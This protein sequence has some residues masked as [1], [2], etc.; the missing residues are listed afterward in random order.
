M[1]EKRKIYEG[2]SFSAGD[3]L[4]YFLSALAIVGGVL[5]CIYH[6]SCQMT[7]RGISILDEEEPPEIRGVEVTSDTSIRLE[8][9]KAVTVESASVSSLEDGSEASLEAAANNPVPAYADITDGGNTVIFRFRQ[10]TKTGGR[11]Q[12][13]SEI[14]DARGDTLT[15]ALPFY[16][17][18]GSIPACAITEVQPKKAG[19][20]KSR[21]L[22]PESPYIVLKTLEDGNLSGL[23]LY[24][25]QN[26]RHYALPAVD[27]KGGETLVLHLDHTENEEDCVSETGSDLGLA[28]TGRS[29][30]VTRDLFFATE[31]TCLGG[32]NE[33]IFLLDRNTNKVKDALTYFKA[34]E[35]GKDKGRVTWNFSSLIQRAIDDG[36]WSGE[37][38]AEYAVNLKGLGVRKPLLRKTIP[39]R[40][41]RTASKVDW[42]IAEKDAY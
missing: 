12:L 13:F 1:E 9:S 40:E 28:K 25:A 21:N 42:I 7:G 31:G 22:H 8:F 41:Q 11:Y 34:S 5:L 37:A 38:S 20:L 27:V 33:V 39:A 14:K 35:S 6:S 17:Y 18:N 16:G 3:M 15:F 29:S 10:A 32:T 4:K 36:A 19:A 26:E 24:C 2:Y 30:S 23:E